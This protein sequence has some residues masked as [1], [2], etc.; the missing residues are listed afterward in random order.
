MSTQPPLISPY[1]RV[2]SVIYSAGVTS[3]SGG[4]EAQ[5]RGCF[6]QL[7]KTLADAGARLA[8]V[9]KV[10]IYLVDLDD[11]ERYLNAIWREYFPVNPP[12]RTTVQAGLAPP[13]VVEME[14]V[15][16]LGP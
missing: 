9:V 5:I 2:G 4:A 6:A 11:R 15:A 7:E 16:I 12:A 10:N 14:L 13:A 3:S 1:R 8:D